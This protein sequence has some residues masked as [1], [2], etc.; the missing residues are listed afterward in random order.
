MTAGTAQHYG[1]APGGGKSGL[2]IALACAVIVA[3]M[4]GLS[5]AAVPL[6][7]LFC[8]VTGYGGT[9]N[10]A[11]GDAGAVIEREMTVRFDGN[12][13]SKMP[14]DF[15]PASD[16]VTLKVGETGLA[17]Y[18]ARNTS[19]KAIVGTAT[20]N[21]TPQ[22]AGYYFTKIDCF[23]FTEQRLEPGQRVDMPVTFFIDPAIEDDPQ[24]DSVKTITLSYTFFPK[25]DASAE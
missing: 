17:F 1:A 13:S 24:L 12:V 4:V 14:W 15:R 7:Q 5:F 25:R 9:T 2:K 22:Q 11:A 16:P 20:F 3:G 21:V 8:Q 10:R 18:E 19:D 6:Y 23:C